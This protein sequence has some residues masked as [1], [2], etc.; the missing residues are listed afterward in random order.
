MRLVP[1]DCFHARAGADTRRFIDESTQ[2]IKSTNSL[3]IKYSSLL[4]QSSQLIR[5]LERTNYWDR[6]C[7]LAG[8]AFFLCTCGWILKRRVFDK[9]VGGLASVIFGA[10]RLAGQARKVPVA[11]SSALISPV[12]EVVNFV[13]EGGNQPPVKLAAALEAAAPAVE[14]G[15]TLAAVV[16]EG[17]TSLS[18]AA[19]DARS[20]DEL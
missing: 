2:T 10:G 1:C 11:S 6:I 5:A 19:D 7:I 8:V 14:G 17:K 4:D 9:A 13:R 3:Y 15:S 18:A 16:I 12:G 20:R